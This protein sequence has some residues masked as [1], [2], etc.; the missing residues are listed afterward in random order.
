MSKI[1]GYTKKGG[2]DWFSSDAYSDKEIEAIKDPEGGNEISLPTAI[3][4]PFARIDLVKTAFRN[5]AKTPDLKAHTKGGNVISSKDDEKLVS[6]AL[7]LAEM[8]FN[9]DS[10]K[11]KIKIIAWDR[12]TQIEELKKSSDRHR[13]LAETLELYLEQDKASYN[14]DL[15]ERLYLI[16]YNH[17]IIGC[18]SP[19]TLFFATANDLTHAQIKLTKN[20]ITFD[21]QYAPLY[22][23]DKEFQRYLYLL[24]KAN[25]RLSDRMRD[26][27]DY[28]AKNLKKLDTINPQLYSELKTLSAAS[29]SSNYS[30][31]NT[32]VTGDVVEII[33]DVPLRKRKMENLVGSVSSSDFA[34]LSSK[35][36][37]ELKPLVLQNSLN[38]PFRY[39]NDK[40][41]NT[42]KVPYLDSETIL[43]R[44]W[45]PGV[46]IQYP[47]LTVSDFLE[48]YLIRLVYP[49]NE[50]KFFDG[51]VNTK[52]GD[53]SKGYV[54]PLKRQFF[55][56]FTS[57]D[58][59]GSSSLH[60]KPRIE[61]LQL[62][63]GAVRV[64]LSIPVARPGES[65]SFERT[66]YESAES[67][68]STPDEENNKGV[69]AELQFSVA[70]FPFIKTNDPN[71][72]PCYRVQLVDRD[73]TGALKNT[74]YDLVFYSNAQP[75][76]V[77]ARG[78]KIRSNKKTA[79]AASQ[80]YVLDK[81]FDF[82]QIRNSIAPGVSGII[83]PH[84]KLYEPGNEVFSFAVDFGTTNTHI[85][86]KIG[87]GSPKPFDITSNDIQ[88]ATFFH[89]IKTTD[90]F[91]GT[92]AIAIRELIDHE[93][94]P[95][96][97]GGGTEFKFPHRT[98]IAESHSLNIETETFSLADF[99]IPFIYEKKAAKDK[100]QSNLKWAKKE[101]GNEKRVS[102]FFEEIMMLLRNKV[103]F[104]R[105]NLSQ[106]RL[107]WF[108]PSSMKPA[109]KSSLESTLY[110]LFK[111]YFNP[112]NQP[113]G[114]T[115]SLAPF[116]YFK[117][118]NKL[119]GGSYKPVVSV[120]IG[121]GT[122]DIVV[123]KSNKPLLLTSFK[124][125]ANTIFGDGFS[126]YGAASSNGLIHKY[127]PHYEKL[128]SENKFY[129]LSK[130]LSSIKEKNKA[131]DLN[132]FF[133]SIEG[134]QK[135]KDKKLFSYNS[136]LANNEDLKILFI[137]FYV[138]IIYHIAEL[139]KHKKIEMPK[140]L[141]FSGTGSK[142]LNIISP[143]MKILAALSKK[144][145]EGVYGQTFD[146]DGLTIETEK[147]MPKEVTC[148]GGLMSNPE[149]LAIDI[150]DIKATLTCAESK[151]IEK[152]TYDQLNNDVKNDIVNYVSRFNS[153]FLKLNAQYS[154]ADYFGISAKSLEIFKEEANKHLRDY[155]EEGLEYNKKL[156]ETAA[157]EKEIEETLFFYPLT[158]V[159]NN[160][161][162]KLT[163]INN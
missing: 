70:L 3:P 22:E 162:S 103:L 93:F 63:A 127:F 84:W 42:I 30:E 29:Y 126:E 144:I 8:I 91:G 88:I 152:L 85:E 55:D 32:G 19:A 79:T 40:W 150:K 65:I 45:L 133:F 13:R 27:G 9:F 97:L 95:Q 104:N 128:L 61:M 92:G 17:K 157:D 44:R 26:F 48:P 82:I 12:K 11:D 145:F 113:V 106:T 123:F 131:E 107:V 38:K 50:E 102:A 98:V 124:F 119:Q 138:A 69:I 149:D 142:I 158:G 2:K 4:S 146:S 21:E 14:F 147:E 77:S 23:R 100:V 118:V 99:N 96:L 1:F 122:T 154:F 81:E 56:Y 46:R 68:L 156:D 67:R 47:Y 117:G 89:P 36:K 71:I 86:Y 16:E 121:G 43:E 6:D 20:D 134:N 5:I 37:G 39:A 76:E 60:N 120:D 114:I 64:T 62:P 125:A 132:A 41:D 141:V 57:D 49:I 110:E 159:I 28:L 87:N 66:Y 7:D 112:L 80:Y 148:K 33:I 163:Q 58:L 24:F 52:T 136:L 73:I 161:S 130:V 101:A 15:L 18:T 153:F 105:G 72:N 143:D 140:H 51:N 135:I 53:G 83:I 25:A 90:D 35:Y 115:E 137:Y 59:A 109:R 10:I 75:E 139:M 129:D 31:L 155:L 111:L 160:L 74:D 54:L 34:I 116:Y 78:M 108:Y 94:V 151:G